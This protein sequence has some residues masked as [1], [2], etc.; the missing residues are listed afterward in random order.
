MLNLK[1]I[2]VNKPAFLLGEKKYLKYLRF[3]SYVTLNPIKIK[4]DTIE[5]LTKP[6][7]FAQIYK[8]SYKKKEVWIA[9][10]YRVSR[11]LRGFSHAGERSLGRY[12]LEELLKGEKICTAIDVGANI[13]EFSIGLINRGVSEIFCFEPD[14]VS[15]AC[16]KNNFSG[17]KSIKFSNFAASNVNKI[18]DFYLSSKRADSSL[19]KPDFFEKVIKVISVKLDTFLPANINS[20]DLLKIEAEG[21]E[22]E[23]ILGSLSILDKIKFIVVDS[24]PERYGEKTDKEVRKI[25]EDFDYEVKVF[26]DGIVHAINRN[27]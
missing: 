18:T 1:N 27:L 14:P 8:V 19:V 4:T 25:L 9:D 21:A 3:L 10:G 7:I 15:F 6:Y 13:G 26:D 22:P 11:L 2:I 24:S 20:I 17:D 16:L 23:V 12:R 5:V